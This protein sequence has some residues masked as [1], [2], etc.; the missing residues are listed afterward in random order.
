MKNARLLSRALEKSE[1]YTVLSDIHRQADHVA[2]V[3]GVA[4]AA[5]GF[6]ENNIEVSRLFHYSQ[7]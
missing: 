2:A 6:D 3:K 4:Q 7:P 1:Y 5:L